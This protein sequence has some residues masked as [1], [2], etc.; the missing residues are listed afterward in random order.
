M[1]AGASVPDVIDESAAKTL[2]GSRWT[3]ESWDTLRGDSEFVTKEQLLALAAT[4]TS[5]ALDDDIL[6]ALVEARANPLACA[7]RIRDR[8]GRFKGKVYQA[9]DQ[10]APQKQTKEGV[11]AVEDALQYLA[12]AE[13]L[14]D[15]SADQVLG[16]Q[17]AAADHVADVGAVGTASHDSSDGS[18]PHQRHE[19]YGSWSGL[20]GECIWYGRCSGGGRVSGESIIDD[21]II[22]DGVASRGHRHCI[23]EARYTVAGVAVGKHAVYGNMVAIE[24]AAA[25]EGDA[26]KVEAR[27]QSGP[28][29]YN[30]FDPAQK[31]KQ[32]QNT[33]WKLGKCAGCKEDIRGGQVV[34]FGGK[35]Y[36]GECFVCCG[37]AMALVGRKLDK[38]VEN[39]E[40]FC[41]P[42]WTERFAV[43]CAGAGCGKKITGSMLTVKSGGCSANYC[44]RG[45]VQAKKK[46]IAGG[47]GVGTKKPTMMG[48]AKKTIVGMTDMYGGLDL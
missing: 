28:K 11:F 6:R 27:R 38:K 25:Y 44:G 40:V 42:C 22:D 41:S 4:A 18:H 21:L 13:Q 43:E 5:K 12:T 23:F 30:I 9:P 45:C 48:E 20:S 39:E 1:G 24:F 8:M 10:T 35:K 32:K 7:R 47:R 36:H 46:K 26:G 29:I 15:F 14:P 2:Y 3:K 37:C 17:L 16:L 34:E 33:Q 31:Q 19:R